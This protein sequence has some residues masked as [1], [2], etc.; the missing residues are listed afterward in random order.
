M[1]HINEIKKLIQFHQHTNSTY[2]SE[3]NQ[4]NKNSSTQHSTFIIQNSTLK[5]RGVYV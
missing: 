4:F 2:V 1:E 3:K 5:I